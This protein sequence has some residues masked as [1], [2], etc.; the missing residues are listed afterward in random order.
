MVACLPSAATAK[1]HWHMV[2]LL[3][4][5]SLG[6]SSMGDRGSYRLAYNAEEGVSFR[7]DRGHVGSV[8]VQPVP[9][10]PSGI[11]PVNTHWKND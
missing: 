4:R 1:A 9:S 2:C 3:L 6:A 11:D 5:T 7:R 10:Q 8:K